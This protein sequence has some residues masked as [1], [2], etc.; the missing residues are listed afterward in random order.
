MLTCG[1]ASLRLRMLTNKLV[2]WSNNVQGSVFAVVVVFGAPVVI[3]LLV[4][5]HSGEGTV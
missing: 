5:R 1:D 2:A 3:W 4:R